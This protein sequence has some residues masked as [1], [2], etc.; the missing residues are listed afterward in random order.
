MAKAMCNHREF[1]IGLYQILRISETQLQ[2]TV[3]CFTKYF[4]HKLVFKEV[5]MYQLQRYE[6]EHL[7]K[8]SLD[9]I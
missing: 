5:K 8:T 6:Y 1:K 2:E 7:P 9:M 4:V 3:T